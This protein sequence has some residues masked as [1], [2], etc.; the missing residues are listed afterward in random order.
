MKKY[1]IVFIPVLLLLIYIYRKP[2]L[3][4]ITKTMSNLPR[5][6]RNNN[7]GNIRKTSDLW[8]GEVTGSDKSFKTFVSMEYGYRAMFVLLRSYINKGYDT[9]E[10]IIN[11]YAPPSENT[12]S[13]YIKH[14]S[15]RTGIA[16][17]KK[18]RF[19]D[20]QSMKDIVAAISRSENGVKANLE[21][22]EKG[23]NLI[24]I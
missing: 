11:R 4:L 22:V 15:E 14:V 7:P 19:S 10:K 9:I 20:S 18:L 13:S 21:E 5:G 8:Q 3:K 17:N 2:S 24:G 1:L 23:F 12:T 6:L 16:K